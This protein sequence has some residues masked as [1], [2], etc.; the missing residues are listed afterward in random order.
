MTKIIV[1]AEGLSVK[2]VA[3]EAADAYDDAYGMVDDSL[4]TIVY[5][6]PHNRVKGNSRRYPEFWFGSRRTE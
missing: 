5:R 6:P 4:P 2:G 3:A 1:R